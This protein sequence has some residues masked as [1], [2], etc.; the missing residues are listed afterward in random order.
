MLLVT[1][2]EPKLTS[3]LYI[4]KVDVVR[5]NVNLKSAVIQGGHGGRQNKFY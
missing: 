1:E 3:S 4:D 5:S 2:V